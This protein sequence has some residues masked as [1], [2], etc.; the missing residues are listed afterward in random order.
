MTPDRRSATAAAVGATASAVLVGA[1]LLRK[2]RSR[3]TPARLASDLRGNARSRG[4]DVVRLYQSRLLPPGSGSG[5]GKNRRVFVVTGA[6]SGLGLKTSELL[7]E[8]GAHVILAV[9]DVEAGERV[10]DGIVCGGGSAEAARLDLSS[11]DSVRSFAEAFLSCGRAL[12]GLVNN[13]GVLGL[14]GTTD[15]GFQ[16]TWQTN[17]LSHAFLTYLLLPASTED[18]RVV[19]VSSEMGRWLSPTDVVGSCPP[20]SEGSGMVDYALSKACQVVHAHGLARR[21]SKEGKGRRAFAVEPGLVETNIARHTGPFS[22]W[23]NYQLLGH[24]FLRTED[25]GCASALFCLLAPP[26]DLVEDAG[27]SPSSPVPPFYYADC[28]PK[29]LTK[30]YK[31]A[32]GAAQLA[33]LVEELC[34]RGQVKAS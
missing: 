32:E 23:I 33:D 4:S 14:S 9:R 8:A 21:F 2:L 24:F 12:S 1:Y 25:E 27:N 28:A 3:P 31:D 6:T 34:C 18:F 26:E 19:N 11:L 29:H 13:A 10:V 30:C 15:D 16:A 22:R 20:K 17:F 7:A 5:V